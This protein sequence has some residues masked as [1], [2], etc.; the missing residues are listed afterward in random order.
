MDGTVR[1]SADISEAT[2][3]A[4]IVRNDGMQVDLPD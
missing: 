4:L 1:V 3:R 2:M